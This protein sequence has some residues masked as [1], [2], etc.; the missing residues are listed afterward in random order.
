MALSPSP[1][2]ALKKTQGRPTYLAGPAF[3]CKR[4]SL[5]GVL[6]RIAVA[7]D[8]HRDGAGCQNQGH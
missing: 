3:S 5:L 2:A 6:L 4:R 8:R 1:F 7:A